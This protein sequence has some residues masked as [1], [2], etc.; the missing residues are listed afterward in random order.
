MPLIDTRVKFGLPK[1]ETTVD[2]CI[3][4]TELEVEG[5]RVV[6]GALA[7]RVLEVFEAS[8]EDL[9]PAPTINPKYKLDFIKGMIPYDEK[10]LML[11]DIS[12]VFSVD[13]IINL[14]QAGEE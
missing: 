6:V 14:S 7:D 4:V 3:I 13:E 2:S 1:I 5:E 8:M 10:F 9:K 11:L 12:K